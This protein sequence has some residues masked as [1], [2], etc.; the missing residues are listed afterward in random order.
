[1]KQTHT[2]GISLEE[3]DIFIYWFSY[4]LKDIITI[5]FFNYTIFFQ[6]KKQRNKD[7]TINNI[8]FTPPHPAGIN[9]MRMAQAQP[10]NYFVDT[11]SVS[12]SSGTYT[13]ELGPHHCGYNFPLPTVFGATVSAHT[14]NSTLTHTHIRTHAYKDKHTQTYIHR[15]TYTDTHTQTHLHRHT[16]TD[17]HTQTLDT[18]TQ[19]HI[20]VYSLKKCR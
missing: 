10:N 20:L 18:H 7:E 2:T 5:H 9:L 17:T 15:H 14:H 6:K 8:Y 12:E 13:V 3:D 16:Y 11:V 4:Y 19:T 1:M